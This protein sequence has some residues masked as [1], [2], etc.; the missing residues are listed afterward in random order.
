MDSAGEGAGTAP[1]ASPRQSAGSP[2]ATREESEVCDR[3]I[4]SE[5]EH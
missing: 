1:A 3:S 2:L 5:V 4:A